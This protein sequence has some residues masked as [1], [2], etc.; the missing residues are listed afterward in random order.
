[1][2]ESGDFDRIH[3]VWEEC[4]KIGTDFIIMM[5]GHRFQ[6][7]DEHGLDTANFLKNF[8]INSVEGTPVANSHDEAYG[9]RFTFTIV[10]KTNHIVDPAKWT[11]LK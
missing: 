6:Y 4:E 8:D 7:E 2:E 5:N 9:F 1:V 10:S 11:S 3:E